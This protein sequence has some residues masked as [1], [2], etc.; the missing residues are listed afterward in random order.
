[1]I[2]HAETKRFADSTKN[3]AK[4]L[5]NRTIVVTRARAQATEF[6]DSLER[7]GARIVACPTIEIIEPES[8]AQLDEAIDNLYGYDWLIFTSVNGVN[9]FLRRLQTLGH[10]ASALDELR[11][12]AIGEATF[13]CLREAQVHVDVIPQDSKA[14]GVFASLELYIGGREKLAG[15][16]FLIPRAAIARDYLPRALEAAGARVDVATTYRTV[17]PETSGRGRIEALLAGGAVDC[18]T[19]TSAS[20][21]ENFARLFDATDLR[22]LLDGVAVACIGEITAAAAAELNLRTNIQPRETTTQALS[23][24]IRDYFAARD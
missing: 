9:Y 12:C 4:P 16:R 19:F 5:E 7:D 3:F 23:L 18:I 8:Y 22:E 15:L 21:V 20:T 2:D 14:E 13:N 10:D 11:V 17:R 1:M 24:A 6:I